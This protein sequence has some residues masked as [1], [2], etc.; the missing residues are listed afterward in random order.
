M[1]NETANKSVN[2]PITVKLQD[3]HNGKMK[4]FNPACETDVFLLYENAKFKKYTF[5][6]VCGQVYYIEEAE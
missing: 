1:T 3:F 5:C 6:N 4:C 2:I